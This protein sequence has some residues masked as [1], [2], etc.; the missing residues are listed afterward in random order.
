MHLTTFKTY[1]AI[2]ETGSLVR[3]SERL[4]I[5]QST[6]TAR[7]QSLEDALGTTLMHRHKRGITL[8]AAGLKFK[9]Y[10]EVMLNLWWQAQQETS[11][12]DGVD[13]LCNIGCH[14]DL[15]PTLGQPLFDWLTQEAPRTALSARPGE[16]TSLE[17]DLTNGVI[18]IALCYQPSSSDNQISLPVGSEALILVSPDPD[19]SIT[20]QPGYL[21]VDA[22][23]QFARSHTQTYTD[24]AVAKTHF[25]STGWALEHLLRHGGSA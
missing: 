19:A 16:Q 9:R 13:D 6:V 14:I 8:T 25:G 12:P 1:L 23:E 7:L 3:A 10:A 22:G 2:V 20:H 15:W 17:D 4:N 18:D 21:Y 5:T 11:L 24:A